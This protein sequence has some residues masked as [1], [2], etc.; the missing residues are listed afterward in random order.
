MALNEKQILEKVNSRFVV[1]EQKEYLEH[2][3]L[4]NLSVLGL[5]T[6]PMSSR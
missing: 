5:S 1:S 4:K 6:T 3:A 2:S